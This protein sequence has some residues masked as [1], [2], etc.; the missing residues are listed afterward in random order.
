MVLTLQTKVVSL[1]SRGTQGSSHPSLRSCSHDPCFELPAPR[2]GGLPGQAL[3]SVV[4]PWNDSGSPARPPCIVARTSSPGATSATT[5]PPV[6]VPP[7]LWPERDVCAWPGDDRSVPTRRHSAPLTGPPPQRQHHG[8]R[9]H[10]PTPGCV[11]DFTAAGRRAPLPLPP[12]TADR[13]KIKSIVRNTLLAS[14]A[15]PRLYADVV[16]S[17]AP[18]SNEVKILAQKYKEIAIAPPGQ[19]DSQTRVKNCTHIKVTE[20]G[21]GCPALRGEQFCYFHQGMLRTVEVPDRRLP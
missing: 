10:R 21:C 3:G 7:P 18:N 15:F 8:Q 5:S 19:H 9:R 6:C 11:C 14:P 16:L 2:G 4:P 17:S 12:A 13:I 20:V 1:I